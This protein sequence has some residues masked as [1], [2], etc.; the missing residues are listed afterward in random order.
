M[1]IWLFHFPEQHLALMWSSPIRNSP[2]PSPWPTCLESPSQ[3]SMPQTLLFSNTCPD[4]LYSIVLHTLFPSLFLGVLS[5]RFLHPFFIPFFLGL[6]RTPLVLTLAVSHPRK[7]LT[8]RQT[9][10]AGHPIHL[11]CVLVSRTACVLSLLNEWV[12]GMGNGVRMI[13]RILTSWLG[14]DGVNES[15]LTLVSYTMGQWIWDEVLRQGTWL[16][17]ESWQTEKITD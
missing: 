5:P 17:S 6:L 4:N 16:Y 15:K 2:R 10:T 3:P 7:P 14:S 1:H 12:C 9:K 13:P 11:S 8:L